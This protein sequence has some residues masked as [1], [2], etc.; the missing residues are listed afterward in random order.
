MFEAVCV[1]LLYLTSLSY[2]ACTCMLIAHRTV[3]RLMAPTNVSVHS[4]MPV[5]NESIISVCRL[6]QQAFP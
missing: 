1:L 2:T 6:D 3:V 5:T 4:Q